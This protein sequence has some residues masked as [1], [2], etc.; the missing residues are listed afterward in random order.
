MLISA[1]ALL[2][3]KLFVPP[4]LLLALTIGFAAHV[5]AAEPDFVAA[6]RETIEN[7]RNF[8]RVDTSSPPGNETRGAEFLKAILEKEGIVCEL[9][10]SDPARLNLVARLK[11]SG[12]K[13]PIVLMGH[14]DVVGVER[15]KWTVDPFEGA[16]KDGFLYG[17]GASDD[18]CMTTVCLEVML[19][20]KRLNVSLDRD[21]IF[22]AEADEE[23]TSHGM[24]ELIEKH[25]DK[26]DCEFALNEGGGILAE[27]GEV[28]YV[29]IATSEKVPR[30]LFL[31]SKGTS[32][33]ASRPRPDNAVVH[34]AAAVA[35]VGTWQPPMRLNETTRA[36]FQRLAKISSP[37]EAW[38]YTHFDDPVVG[39]Q[40][41]EIFRLTEKY[42]FQNSVLRTSI[43]PTVLKTGFRFNVIP[44][45]GLATLDVRALPDEDMSAFVKTLTALIADPS[46]TVTAY[47]GS[48][49]MPATP[50]SRLDTEMFSALERA[51]QAVFPGKSVIPLMLTGATDSSFLRA[52][53]VQAY[54]LG[55]IYSNEDGGDRMHGNDERVQIAGVKDFLQFVYRAT[56]DV[57]GAK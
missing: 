36:Y 4:S 30:T 37:Q 27:A 21:V 55:S 53:G 2:F 31:A 9:L 12:K 16:M 10:G 22:I 45:D 39:T 48:S 15:E 18:K 56:I 29:G 51:Q 57:A 13:R 50:P 7:L 33:H 52:K 1:T 43:S 25:W 32:G 46:I 23:S 40:V 34:L 47:T 35:K 42:F 5:G 14:T 17:R 3:M 8:V 54:G 38:L 11:G 28:K 24:V 6:H 44:A 49:D 19:L 41:Q 20:L 26:I